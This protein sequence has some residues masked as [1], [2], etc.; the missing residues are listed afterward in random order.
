MALGYAWREVESTQDADVYYGSPRSATARLTINASP[1]THS[2]LAECFTETP[3]TI[4]NGARGWHIAEDI[5]HLLFQLMT[6]AAESTW[7][8]GRHGLLRVPPDSQ[9]AM[10]RATAS[11]CVLALGDAFRAAGLPR[12]IPRWP[13][14]AVAAAAVSHDVDYPEV[15]RALEPL[16]IVARQG[17]GGIGA[18]WS[19]VTGRRHHWHF[20]TWMTLERSLGIASVF[21]FAARRGSVLQYAL[22]RPD[23]L[24]SIHDPRIADVIRMLVAGG[25]EVGL[26]ASYDTWR[27][28]EMLVSE[29]AALETVTGQPIA[30]LRHHYWHLDEVHPQRTLQAH[31]DTGFLYDASLAH[32]SV[33]G[34]R[35]G[36]A[37]PYRP[38]NA[39]TGRPIETLQLP[40]SWMEEHSFSHWSGSR[41]DATTALNELVDTVSTVGGCLL[42]DLHEYMVDEV[43]HPG[44]FA[45]SRSL[46]TRVASDSAFWTATPV[47][48]ARHWCARRAECEAASSGLDPT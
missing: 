33:M 43:L 39:D 14:G 46:L 12:G 27:S 29:R 3:L 22:G 42:V 1:W 34:F 26:H 28:T 32:D 5:P 37:W 31:A 36:V 30:G 48:I 38:W 17:V 23:P 20:D 47:E 11:R 10:R 21:Y 15:V 19:A 9:P 7:R 24:Y 45:M 40:T 13:R 41:A 18:A 6:G 25:W 16:R 2:S 4:T 8:R 44:R 35:H